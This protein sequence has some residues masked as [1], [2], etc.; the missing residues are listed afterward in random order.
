VRA[1]SVIED[2]ADHLTSLIDDLSTPAACRQAPWPRSGEI[3]LPPLLERVAERYRTQARRIPSRRTCLRSAGSCGDE[4]RLT[5]VVTNLLSNAVIRRTEGY[6]LQAQAAPAEVIVFNQAGSTRRRAAFD[7][8]FRSPDV[9]RVTRR[10]LG[11]F[12][13]KA[14]VEARRRIRVDPQIRQAHVLLLRSVA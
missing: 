13:A 9:A 12:L 3:S 11:L 4:Q 14:I 2:E 10:G 7:R 1:A 6:P 8:F 5:Q